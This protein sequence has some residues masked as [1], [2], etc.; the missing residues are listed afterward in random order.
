MAVR[1]SAACGSR[2]GAAFGSL[3]LFQS[4]LMDPADFEPLRAA[5]A[6]AAKEGTRIVIAPNHAR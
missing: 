4:L 6:Q 5:A 1:H 2:C 3:R